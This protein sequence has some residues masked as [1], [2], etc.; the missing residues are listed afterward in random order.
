MGQNSNFIIET[1][2]KS[3]FSVVFNH[4]TGQMSCNLSALDPFL[5]P[6]FDHEEVSLKILERSLTGCV[7]FLR[8]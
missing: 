3:A 4:K 8:L 1:C 5:K 7:Y 2:E 6:I